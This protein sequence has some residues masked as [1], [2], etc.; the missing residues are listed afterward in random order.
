MKANIIHIG[1]SLG[2][3]IPKPVIKQCGFENEVELEVHKHELIIRTAHQ[4]RRKW[5]DD[6]AR[7]AHNRDDEPVILF[8]EP[9]SQWDEQEW[10][11]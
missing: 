11:W 6:F 4:P 5:N 2:I 9:A 7:M 3:R 8:E 10:E 1:N